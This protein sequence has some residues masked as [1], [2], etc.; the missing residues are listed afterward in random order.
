[1]QYLKTKFPL[2]RSLDDWRQ[3]KEVAR[4]NK[5]NATKRSVTLSDSSVNK[6]Q[7]K[8]YITLF[9]LVLNNLGVM[10][11]VFDLILSTKHAQM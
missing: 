8:V 4:H 2:A 10:D 11:G 3:L 7:Y 5:L 6:Q 1:M 9:F